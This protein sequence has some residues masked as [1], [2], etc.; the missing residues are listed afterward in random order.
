MNDLGGLVGNEMAAAREAAAATGTDP[1]PRGAPKERVTGLNRELYALL[2]DESLPSLIPTK[3]PGPTSFRDRKKGGVK[4]E[5][6]PFSNGARSDKAKLHHW[7]KKHENPEEYSFARFNKKPKMIK[8]TAQEYE[9]HCK[10]ASWS[11]E[12]T[13]QLMAL[14][15]RYELRWH[16]IYDRYQPHPKQQAE[17]TLEDMKERFYGM[18][19]AMNSQ[20]LPHQFLADEHSERQ[21]RR[22]VGYDA[23]YERER[24]IKLRA[25]YDYSGSQEISDT[26]TMEKA[27]TIDATRKKRELENQDMVGSDWIGSFG[28]A[29]VTALEMCNEALLKQ[30]GGQMKRAVVLRRKILPEQP[31]CCNKKEEPAT[32][33]PGVAGRTSRRASAVDTALSEIGYDTGDPEFFS[34]QSGVVPGLPIM[35]TVGV[36][37]NLYA[38]RGHL[39]TYFGLQDDLQGAE[40][41]LIRLKAQKQSLQRSVQQAEAKA[42]KQAQAAAAAAYHAQLAAAAAAE[43]SGAPQPDAA[44]AGGGA[45]AAAGAAAA[46][47]AQ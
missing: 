8:Y 39:F 19:K 28:Q 14:C 31:E 12:E 20:L 36:Q 30:L 18:V 13:D 21:V 17:R 2:S 4:W 42:K 27:K 35:A 16:V 44:A 11:K 6:K 24:K 1:S 47:A 41:Y 22:V 43:T 33:T 34:Y 3:Q 9:Q 15:E 10:S 29:D 25:Y 38:L 7:W 37:A 32:T 45:A 46:P 5:W 23:N 40:N 26:S